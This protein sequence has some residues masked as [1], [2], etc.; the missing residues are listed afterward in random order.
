MWKMINKQAITNNGDLY[1]KKDLCDWKN[2]NTFSLFI[3]SIL[4]SIKTF[5][6]DI[7][8]IITNYKLREHSH[9]K[10]YAIVSLNKIDNF[11]RENEE[12]S[13]PI[14]NNIWIKE[15]LPPWWNRTTRSSKYK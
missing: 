1:G 5:K 11:I 2:I 12:K 13:L 6:Q 4:N 7:D 14:N 8:E 10:S 3:K 9:W 15:T